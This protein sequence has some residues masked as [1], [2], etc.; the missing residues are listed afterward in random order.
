MD[1][2]ILLPFMEHRGKAIAKR[3]K[4]YGVKKNFIYKKLRITK[5]TFDLW[6]ATPNLP[7][8]DVER[9]G[10]IIR[11][12]FTIDFPGMIKTIFENEKQ[13]TRV[14]EPMQQSSEEE[15]KW[16]VLNQLK[17]INEK[18]NALIPNK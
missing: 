3:I 17:E 7:D 6:L 1:T 18:L 12:D 9:I 2:E 5:A 11:H 10:T 13:V 15:F 4:E 14:A 8:K 16:N